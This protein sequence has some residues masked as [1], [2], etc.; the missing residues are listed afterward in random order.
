MEE[1]DSKPRQERP[2]LVCKEDSVG[3]TFWSGFVT[4]LFSLCNFWLTLVK[5]RAQLW[6]FE[7][8]SPVSLC[9]GEVRVFTCLC[10]L[11]V[12]GSRA[13]LLLVWL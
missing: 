4:V 13:W 12:A 9:A 10:A 6:R 2:V 7:G 3:S 5:S 8:F 1:K 11:P